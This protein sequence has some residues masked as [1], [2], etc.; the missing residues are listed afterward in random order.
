VHVREFVPTGIAVGM[1]WRLTAN[2][3]VKKNALW[4]QADVYPY[5]SPFAALSEGRKDNSSAEKSNAV[6]SESSDT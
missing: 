4:N 3:F 2:G 1:L 5:V 6:C